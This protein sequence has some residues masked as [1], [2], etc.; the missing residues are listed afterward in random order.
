MHSTFVAIQKMAR[1]LNSCRR[2]DMQKFATKFSIA[3]SYDGK[4][5]LQNQLTVAIDW[6]YFQQTPSHTHP[7][8]HGR[9]A[10]V[11]QLAGARRRVSE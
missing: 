4:V 9:V 7:S 10:E 2:V 6:N 3:R 1:K 8:R 5:S 11:I